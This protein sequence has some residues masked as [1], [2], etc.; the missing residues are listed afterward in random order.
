[1]KIL[2][3]NELMEGSSIDK[4]NPFQEFPGALEQ[5]FRN[6][7]TDNADTLSRFY[8][9]TGALKTDFT[10]TGKRTIMGALQ[11]GKNSLTRYVLNHFYDAN[12]QDSLDFFLGKINVH[13]YNI[14]P[15]PYFPYI[16]IIMLC[17]PFFVSKI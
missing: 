9:G 2:V 17:L 10:K 16:A 1:M 14:Q 3:E 13:Q 8:S 15:A 7:W 6:L 12:N 11:D 5:T 4:N